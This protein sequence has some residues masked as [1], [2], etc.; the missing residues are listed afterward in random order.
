[1]GDCTIRPVGP[2]EVQALA[3]LARQTFVTAVTR[4]N[5]PD[6]LAAYVGRAF[7]VER[8][9]AELG[10]SD[11]FF[12]FFFF[13]AEVEGDL[14]GYLKINTGEAQTE[15]VEVETLEVERIYMDSRQQ[16][17]A[18]AKRCSISRCKKHIG[19]VAIPYGWRLGE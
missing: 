17:R 8:M 1:M 4:G 15:Q 18:S 11:F 2:P 3:E 6:D 5:T 14:A 13:F 19:W 7:S 12:F 10:A 9:A 16:G